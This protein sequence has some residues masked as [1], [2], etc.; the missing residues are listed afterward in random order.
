M[1][2]NDLDLRWPNLSPGETDSVLVIDPNA[3]L[4]LAIP[5]EGFQSIGRRNPEV[6]QRAG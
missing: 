3:A 1:V 5:L 4:A 6:L 2:V